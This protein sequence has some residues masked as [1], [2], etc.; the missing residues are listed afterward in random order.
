MAIN[1]E[2]GRELRRAF[3]D[4]A[5]KDGQRRLGQAY[6]EVAVLAAS[7]AKA[8][9]RGGTP[10]QMKMAAAIKPKSSPTR[11]GVQFARTGEYKASGVA[12]WGA[13]RPIGW[14]AR[15][16]GATALRQRLPAWVGNTWTAATR[17]EGPHRVND[18]LAANVPRYINEL[19]DA[20]DRAAADVG[21][22]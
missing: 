5:G 9:A 3:R 6:K 2:G 7:D 15:K 18:A 1:V 16:P 22:L 13:N 14:Y 17:G 11:A 19:S 12:F 8:G 20:V 4:F 10:L 21:L